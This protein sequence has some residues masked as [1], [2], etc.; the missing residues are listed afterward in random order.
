[1]ASADQPQ[2]QPPSDGDGA[3]AVA[4]AE[5]SLPQ[6]VAR[7]AKAYGLPQQGRSFKD[8]VEDAELQVFGVVQ[9][10]QLRERALQVL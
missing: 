9:G 1:M 6:L 5:L 2:A 8:M 4:A 7:V 3:E 10:G